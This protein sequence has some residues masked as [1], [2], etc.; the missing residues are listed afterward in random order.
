M[1]PFFHNQKATSKKNGLSL[2]PRRYFFRDLI[3]VVGVVLVWR[4]IWHLAD[5]FLFPDNP[6]LSE[7]LG[8]VIGLFLLY[9]PDGDLSHLTGDGHQEHH[10]Y[11]HFDET[12]DSIQKSHENSASKGSN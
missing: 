8:V 6:L 10:H 12:K 1:L 4:S 3:V 9:L 11:H 5:R 7:V 2:R